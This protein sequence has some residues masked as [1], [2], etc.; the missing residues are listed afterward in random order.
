M[1]GKELLQQALTALIYHTSQ[2]RPIASTD[3]AIAAI[4]QALAQPE[5]ATNPYEQAIDDELV[6]CYL[7]TNDDFKDAKA[8]LLAIIDFN[9]GVALQE[10]EPLPEQRRNKMPLKSG[11]RVCLNVPPRE[12]SRTVY[13][14]VHGGYYAFDKQTGTVLAFAGTN[15]VWVHF[16]GQGERQYVGCPTEYLTEIGEKNEQTDNRSI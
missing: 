12:L 14:T 10:A 3:A 4:D 2:T 5:Q 15:G 16:D 8:A 11:A 13:P 1:N 9:C 7:G 6:N